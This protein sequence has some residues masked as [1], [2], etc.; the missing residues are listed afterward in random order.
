MEMTPEMVTL[1]TE[2]ALIAGKKS[3]EAIFDKIRAVKH[4]GNKD[5]IISNLEEIINDL[6]SDKNTLIQIAHGYEDKLVT[7][8]ITDAEIDY[9]TKSII[10]LIEK[11]LGQSDNDNTEKIQANLDMIKSVI[12]KETLNILQILGFNFKEAIGEPL[13]KLLAAL[14]KSKIDNSDKLLEVK[15][16]ELQHEVEYFKICQD[17]EAFDRLKSI[18][19]R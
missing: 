5:E 7:Q 15:L 10:P 6:I 3:V 17:E 4:K 1:G 13:T 16:L 14:I 2:L 12:S 19:N 9:I 8:K 11:L 18:Y